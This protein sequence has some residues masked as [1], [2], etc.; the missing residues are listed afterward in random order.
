MDKLPDAIASCLVSVL[1]ILVIAFLAFLL[2]YI[3]L[4]TNHLAFDSKSNGEYCY[5]HSGFY[6]ADKC[7]T[8]VP[9]LTEAK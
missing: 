2:F 9:T 8:P 6:D 3:G 4:A 7:I 1:G 5:V